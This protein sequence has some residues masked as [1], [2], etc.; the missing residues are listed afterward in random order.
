MILQKICARLLED[1]STYDQADKERSEVRMDEEVCR[2][3]Q[4]IEDQIDNSIN[5]KVAIGD[6]MNGYIQ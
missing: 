1:S 6:R 5:F 4:R 3:I 2:S